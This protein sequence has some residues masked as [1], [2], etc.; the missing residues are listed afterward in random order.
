MLIHTN[1]PVFIPLY[2][3][4]IDFGFIYNLNDRDTITAFSINYIN[5]VN[6]IRMNGGENNTINGGFVENIKNNVVDDDNDNVDTQNNKKNLSDDEITDELIKSL[7]HKIVYE[8]QVKGVPPTEAEIKK[9]EEER[10]DPNWFEKQLNKSRMSGATR[11]DYIQRDIAT[12]YK[13]ETDPATI[14]A[15]QLDTPE[16]LGKWFRERQAR[17]I[18]ERPAELKRQEK[19]EEDMK[20]FLEEKI[21]LLREQGLT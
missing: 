16:K 6:N 4:L 20:K 5:I 19:A 2:K 8:F 9:Y 13:K 18:A 15:Y 7:E 12:G 14:L 3:Y 1:S 17:I 10:K 21:K 11:E